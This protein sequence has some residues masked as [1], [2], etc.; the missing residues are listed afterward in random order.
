MKKGAE[1]SPLTRTDYGRGDSL[2]KSNSGQ[3]SLWLGPACRKKHRACEMCSALSPPW[4]DPVLFRKML[5]LAEQA[6]LDPLGPG[7][8]VGAGTEPK[9]QVCSPG[10]GLSMPVRVMQRGTLRPRPLRR[11]CN[12]ALI[13]CD[14]RLSW[15]CHLK[16]EKLS[17]GW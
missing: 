5:L 14:R 6:P 9:E 12:T 2:I 17:R 13:T 10:P 3:G 11:Y 7:C 15:T 4:L 16:V 1:Q 8:N